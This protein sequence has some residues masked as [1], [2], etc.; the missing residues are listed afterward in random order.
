MDYTEDSTARQSADNLVADS[1][2][3]RKVWEVCAPQEYETGFNTLQG[4]DEGFVDVG[5]GCDALV[6]LSPVSTRGV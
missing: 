2:M 5:C 6:L 4:S 3:M 1:C